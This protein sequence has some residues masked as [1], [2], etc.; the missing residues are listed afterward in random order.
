MKADRAGPVP[1][2]C[3]Q[4]SA[5]R[6]YRRRVWSARQLLESFTHDENC[7]L[8]LTYNDETLP[9]DGSVS[10]RD[11]QL[12]L[13]RLRLSVSPTPVRFFGVGEYGDR[14]ER[15]H[16]HLSLFGMSPFGV[17]GRATGQEHFERSWGK[18]IAFAAEFNGSTAGYVAGYV[19]K[20]LTKPTAELGGR[21][22]EFA[23]MSNR[24]GIGFPAIDYLT[25]STSKEAGF[26]AQP[27]VPTSLKLGRR[28]LVMGRYL[29]NK[30]REFYGFTPDY[31]Q[32]LKHETMDKAAAE[33]QLLLVSTPGATSH[34]QAYLLSIEQKLANHIAKQKIRE[35][36]RSL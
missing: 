17:Y 16:Y 35:S 19:T 14:T 6:Q 34:K 3:G 24:P 29:R 5:C 12:F 27:D 4:C 13:K 22:P 28:S 9:S 21:H 18:G 33:M 36:A 15:P 25:S 26:D 8:T 10:P 32:S 7:F 31:I 30:Y 1:L 2:G 23:R 11:L 20:K